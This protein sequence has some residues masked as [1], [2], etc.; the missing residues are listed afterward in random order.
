[1]ENMA[2]QRHRSE[3]ISTEGHEHARTKGHDHAGIPIGPEGTRVLH[4]FAADVR[5][6]SE[7]SES[8]EIW[9]QHY[10]NEANH[11]GSART[12]VGTTMSSGTN[13]HELEK[14]HPRSGPEVQ[15]LNYARK[16][17]DVSS[18]LHEDHTESV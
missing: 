4:E 3:G 13:P 2:Q 1:M 12:K 5:D 6:H 16:S 8:D 14:I 17:G 11:E 7:S 10:L 18:G 15:K 9:E